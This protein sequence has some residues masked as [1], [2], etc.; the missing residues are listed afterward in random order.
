L[1]TIFIDSIWSASCACK[2]GVNPNSI[3]DG[4]AKLRRHLFMVLEH[5]A[6]GW[7]FYRAWGEQLTLIA[8]KH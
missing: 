3:P 4:Y 2:E 6:T 7:P 8:V 1:K 5:L